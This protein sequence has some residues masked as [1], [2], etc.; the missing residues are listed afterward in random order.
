MSLACK[1]DRC[2]QLFEVSNNERVR[3]LII[4]SVNITNSYETAKMLTKMD[5][6]FSCSEKLSEFIKNS[7]EP[8]DKESQEKKVKE[9]FGDTIKYCGLSNPT[10]EEVDQKD[11]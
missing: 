5:L 6:C 11:E 8:W 10:E 2:G 7:E 3:R 4:N 1:C 9:I